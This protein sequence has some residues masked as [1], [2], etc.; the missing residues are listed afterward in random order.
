MNNASEQLNMTSQIVHDDITNNQSDSSLTFNKLIE[1]FS[2]E[3]TQYIDE[4]LAELKKYSDEVIEAIC[5]LENSKQ[6]K[7]RYF[8]M[9]VVCTE[10]YAF[11]MG[12]GSNSIRRLLQ[13]SGSAA[14]DKST[15]GDEAVVF[16]F[17]SYDKIVNLIISNISKED[18]LKFIEASKVSINDRAGLYSVIDKFVQIFKYQIVSGIIFL[19]SNNI[20]E[21][22]KF[23]SLVRCFNV[24]IFAGAV[25]DSLRVNLNSL[26]DSI[27]TIK[28]LTLSSVIIVIDDELK[29]DR[30]LEQSIIALIRN[31]RMIDNYI[32]LKKS[33]INDLV[34]DLSKVIVNIPRKLQLTNVDEIESSL[35]MSFNN[36]LNITRMLMN[37]ADKFEPDELKK[38]INDNR[39]VIE[40]FESNLLSMILD[41]KDLK[42]LT[43]IN[44]Y[45]Y[46]PLEYEK[47]QLEEKIS[48]LSIKFYELEN[49][50]KE[51]EIEINSLKEKIETYEELNA[52]L[53][54][55]TSAN[56]KQILSYSELDVKVISNL[57]V[58]TMLY[59]K[60]LYDVN[61]LDTFI[62]M[63]AEYIRKLYQ[64]V[65]KV[66]YFLDSKDFIN[67]LRLQSKDYVIVP[68]KYDELLFIQKDAFVCNFVN[69][70]IQQFL[71]DSAKADLLIV[72]DRLNNVNTDIYGG[73]I[74]FKYIAIKNRNDLKLP[75]LSSRIN[76]KACILP[77]TEEATVKELGAFT[78][79]YI[80]KLQGAVLSKL[81]K[82]NVYS[83][84]CQKFI[85]HFKQVYN[86][87]LIE[88]L[89]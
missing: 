60:V 87:D 73:Y 9:P 40:L 22:M 84:V 48:E 42:M 7:F 11:L 62:E 30:I 18:L 16:N 37:S 33:S 53:Q 72:V 1:Q 23:C 26:I 88:R 89:K 83:G 28:L 63:L 78:I 2:P 8:I 49:L 81:A 10:D 41:T 21:V 36:I 44:S 82:L 86:I 25:V 69:N 39:M 6:L 77:F 58:N 57:S 15:F 31:L 19:W 65:V 24:T 54:E 75:H 45:R 35:L 51:K 50:L 43:L 27:R 71:V 14:I 80:D 34:R 4:K 70:K 20:D 29:S 12:I 61:F 38:F 66:V 76:S 47:K 55:L 67:I 64:K 3:L 5:D 13:L 68:D 79:P 85:E 52:K 17:N 74:V 32:F 46:V 59:F 56:L